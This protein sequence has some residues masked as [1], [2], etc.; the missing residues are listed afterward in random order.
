MTY[1]L[2]GAVGCPGLTGVGLAGSGATVT[3]R[4][5]RDT[6]A[7]LVGVAVGEGHDGKDVGKLLVLLIKDGSKK[8][9]FL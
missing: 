3:T 9:S 4:D 8:A 7:D 1:L 6:V 5:G 2:I